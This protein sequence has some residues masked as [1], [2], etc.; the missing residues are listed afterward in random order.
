MSAAGTNPR[1]AE[2]DLRSPEAAKAALRTF[3]RIAEAWRLDT[4]DQ[5]ALLGLLSR[6]TLTNWRRGDL[7][8][9]APDTMERLSYLFGIYAALQVL[10]PNA[11]AAD[12]WIRK[13]NAAP[14]FGGR[15]ALD[16]LRSGKVADLFLVRQYLDAQRGGWA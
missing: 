16:R 2:V 15:S 6:T 10:L 13:P 7:N 8:A 5:M 3:F 9:L 1:S 11:E 12:A 4:R 14:L